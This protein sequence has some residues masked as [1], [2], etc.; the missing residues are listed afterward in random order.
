VLPNEIPDIEGMPGHA[1]LTRQQVARV[2][3][4]TEAALKKWAREGRGPRFTK[5]ESRHRYRVE[6]VREWLKGAAS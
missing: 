6:D 3:N 1:L 4:F 5:I 2:S